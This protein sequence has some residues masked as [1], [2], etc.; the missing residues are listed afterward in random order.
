MKLWQYILRRLLLLIPVL[1]GISLI[2]FGLAWTATKGHLEVQ[3]LSEADRLSE[4]RIQRII[5]QYGYD[6]PAY[7]QYFTYL[8]NIAA[9]DW[10]LSTSVNRPVTDVISGMFPASV[11]LAMVAM[12]F[13]VLVGIPLG[14]LS[15]THRNRPT[16]HLTRFISLSGVSVPV[17]WLALIL[18]LVFAYQL[19]KSGFDFFPLLGRYDSILAAQG[20]PSLYADR[21]GFLLVDTVL[22]GDFVAFWDALRHLLLPG[23]TLAFTTLAIITRMMRAS[24]LEVL[25]L[26]YVRTARAKGLEERVV[27]NRHARRNALIPTTTVIGLSLGGLMGGAVLTETIFS[28]PGLGRWAARATLSVDVAAIMGFVTLTAIIYVLA[29]LVVDVIYAYLDPR[30]RLE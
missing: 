17:F 11:E 23:F 9:G 7:V 12:A 19:G 1:I 29:N 4:E 8:K 15:A 22:A 28:W 3:H 2:T 10:G 6:K 14:I 18:Q 16:D 13:A 25:G 26:D 27:I 5:N 30:V 20:H 21:T 24:M